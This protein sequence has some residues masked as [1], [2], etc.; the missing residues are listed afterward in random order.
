[1]AKGIVDDLRALVVRRDALAMELAE[2]EATVAELRS[3]LAPKGAAVIPNV[4][5]RAEQI[6]SALASGP[7]HGCEVARAIGVLPT[8]VNSY[9]TKAVRSGIIF[10]VS[11]GVYA[12]SAK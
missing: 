10:R 12:R 7:M 9:L 4:S 5:G 2:V 3:L 6:W 8:A 11:K 1:M